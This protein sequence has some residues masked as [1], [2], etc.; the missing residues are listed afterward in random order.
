MEDKKQIIFSISNVILG[1]WIRIREIHW[2]TTNQAKHQ[3]TDSILWRLVSTMDSIVEITS[4]IYDEKIGFNVLKPVIPNTNDLKQI[5]KAC[6]M[7]IESYCG[8]LNDPA[9]NGL[10]AEIDE[11]QADVNKWIYL[12]DNN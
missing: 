6:S 11:F 2:N 10:R 3:L 12:S 5:L 1:S 9:F 4:G 7:K 8:M